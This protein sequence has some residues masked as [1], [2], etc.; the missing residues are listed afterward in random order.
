MSEYKKQ[1]YVPVFY[2]K[3]FSSN[4]KSFSVLQVE[5]QRIINNASVRNQCQE[6]Y[7][8]G[9]NLNL[10]H[11]YQEYEKSW[12][13]AI[14]NIIDGNPIS[15]IDKDSLK[16]FALFQ[17]SRTRAASDYRKEQNKQSTVEYFKSIA[18]SYGINPDK[19]QNLIDSMADEKAKELSTPE[20]II[21]MAKDVRP[22]LNDL[23]VLIINYKTS[24]KLI[25]SDTPVIMINPM[26][27]IHGVGL[28]SMGLVIFFPVDP[29]KLVVIYDGL[30]YSPLG[31]KG[32][33]FISN[34]DNEV[35]VLNTYQYAS[36]NKILFSMHPEDLNGYQMEAE[37]ARDRT[38]NQSIVSA[39]G[40]GVEKIVAM[41]ERIIMYNGN[42]SFCK[43]PRTFRRIP[44][45]C[46]ESLPRF[47]DVETE[48]TLLAKREAII[49]VS[50][51][52]KEKELFG[53]LSK[54]EYK[55]GSK[56]F[57]RQA[58]IYWH[59]HKLLFKTEEELIA[60]LLENERL[61]EKE[62]G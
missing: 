47:C 15:E 2:M 56:E 9:E 31:I 40:N 4:G 36:A 50:S 20:E 37:D 17:R 44:K 30:F 58:Q 28:G 23:Q 21:E 62:N 14:H 59:K 29:T 39:F 24:V 16:E 1:H 3:N 45:E 35:K 25:S 34:D 6:K 7:F 12:S 33:S 43:V 38:K 53:N 11:Q 57:F 42:L 49:N 41:H 18:L 27:G 51:I 61:L 5:K 52:L 8:Y 10:E 46:K 19:H 32:D 54:K 26:C 55:R 60:K 13:A 48:N 22:Y